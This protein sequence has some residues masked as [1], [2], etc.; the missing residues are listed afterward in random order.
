[1]RVWVV[2]AAVVWAVRASGQETPRADAGLAGDLALALLVHDNSVRTLDWD[3]VVTWEAE[4]LGPVSYE[5]HQ[6]FDDLG[7]WG[8]DATE[9]IRRGDGSPVTIHAQRRFDGHRLMTCD[10]DK[11]SGIINEY[12]GER[13]GSEGVDCWLGRHIDVTGQKRL[14]ELLA[15]SKD[16][17]LRGS[18]ERGLPR[19]AATV[20]VYSL[21]AELEV[22]VDPEHGFA[23]R[24][25]TV[26]DRAV[27]VPYYR[28]ETTSFVR[29]DD[30]WLPESGTVETRCYTPTPEQAAALKAALASRGCS[31]ESDITKPEVQAVYAEV[32][33]QV[34]G[35][36]EASSS[37][38]V[39]P[40]EIHATFRAVNRRIPAGLF[41]LDFPIDYSVLDRFNGLVKESGS[42]AWQSR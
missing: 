8:A 11:R 28:Y 38:L 15:Q 31:K 26:R 33:P 4:G 12:G 21:I 17:A 20:L 14:G 9:H 2:L 30:V 35:K 24:S 42:T 32:I 23:P 29:V 40:K 3:Q 5:S 41:V 25:I 18:S 37:W 22:E 13:R 19:I 6:F 7:R 1:M 39:P 27:R 10:I 16:L 34:F 36:D